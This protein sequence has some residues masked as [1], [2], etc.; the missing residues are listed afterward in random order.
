MPTVTSFPHDALPEL[1]EQAREFI[2]VLTPAGEIQYANAS[3]AQVL[4]CDTAD[5]IGRPLSEMIDRPWQ[6]RWQDLLATLQRERRVVEVELT[7]TGR[8]DVPVRVAGDLQA[9]MQGNDLIAA[10]GIWRDVTQQSR[11][12]QRMQA[13]Y[14]TA[15]VLTDAE[16][17]TEATS[18]ILGRLCETFGWNV[19][20]FWT[21]DAETKALR[22]SDCW[23]DSADGL[24]PF[25]QVT[26]GLSFPLGMGMIGRVWQRPEP[27]WLPDVI[28][29]PHFWRAEVAASAGLV[30]AFCFPVV[31]RGQ[32]LGIFEF[33]SGA[34][35]A[36]D[37]DL[38]VALS[39]I[40]RQIGVFCQRLQSQAEL[41]QALVEAKAAIRAKSTFLAN[42]SHELRSP[43]NSIIG[44]SKVLADQM[45]GP[46]NDKQER[47]VQTIHRNG[48]YLLE[49]IDGILDL[50]KI[51]VG[52]TTLQTVPM[53]VRSLLEDV[54]ASLMLQ[55]ETKQITLR[56]HIAADLPLVMAD[57]MRLQQICVN[58]LVN[59][60]K[61]TPAGGQ[62]TL[63]V[64][65]SDGN[66]E[67]AVS[68]T[69]IGIAPEDQERVF[70][71]F[72]QIDSS[73]SRQHRGTGLGLPLSRHLVELHGGRLK[74]RSQLGEGS[75]F[76]FTLPGA[77]H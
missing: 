17:L 23:V 35:E 4:D 47:F 29:E 67:V 50:S 73:L 22:C 58:L 19:G 40:G 54:V 38:L 44:F 69:G 12:Q 42:M 30:S 72:V 68:D 45:V 3:W 66:V 62:V 53:Q 52:Q 74:L 37:D 48:N 75:I 43:L 28:G 70:Q 77:P 41:A 57:P 61:F 65:E 27:L 2:L 11:R 18:Q 13:Q 15:N 24:N 1:V 64:T 39:A 31:D 10:Y 21:V 6:Q 26:R 59:A 14:V 63:Q 8:G 16:N 9:L 51:E 56:Q 34:I 20:A 5:L 25:E 46:L 49:L 55:A 71:P 33:F 60:I 32:V 7:L 76:S 36:P